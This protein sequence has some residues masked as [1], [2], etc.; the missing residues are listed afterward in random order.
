MKYAL[1]AIAV[2]YAVCGCAVAEDHLAPCDEYFAGAYGQRVEAI[3]QAAM[4]GPANF[5]VTVIPSFTPEWSLSVSSVEGRYLLTYVVFDQSLWN[6]SW[7]ETA[8][9]RFT[10]DPSKGHARGKATTR[11][12]TAELYDALR[13]EWSRSVAATRQSRFGLDGET[14]NFRLPGKCA[15]AWSPEAS[16]RNGKLVELVNALVRLARA[17]S[18]EPAAKMEA[19]ALRQVRELPRIPD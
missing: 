2:A 19:D 9:D 7:V 3:A 15:N 4:P 6:S 18:A 12:I 1:P 8:P 5:W 16:T 10:N 13:S 14:Y 11:R 17:G